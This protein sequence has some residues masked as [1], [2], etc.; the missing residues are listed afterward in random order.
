M[1]SVFLPAILKFEYGLSLTQIF[2]YEAV[3]SCIILFFSY[4]SSLS[5]TARHGTVAS[6]F[7]GVCVFVLN[8]VV[9]YYAKQF[10]WLLLL[11][12]LFS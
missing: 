8:F 1:I 11:S 4:Y 12:P 7:L 5:F 6:M 9:L 2:L 3:F 10:P